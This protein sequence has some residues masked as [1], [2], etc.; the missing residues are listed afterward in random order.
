MTAMTGWA[1]DALLLT[2]L[3]ALFSAGTAK[4]LR[5]L[6]P[7]SLLIRRPLA[8][9]LCMAWWGVQL[10]CGCWAWGAEAPFTAGALAR[11]F[12]VSGAAT[13]LS[14]WLLWKSEEEGG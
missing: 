6:A 14:W 5:A 12:V 2:V 8:C 10:G 11:L 7:L 13:W 1:L 3:L 9:S 4:T